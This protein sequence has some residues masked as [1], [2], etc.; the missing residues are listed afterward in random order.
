MGVV[1]QTKQ[2]IQSRAN[3]IQIKV[4]KFRARTSTF[5]LIRTLR[6]CN[7]KSLISKRVEKKKKFL[8]MKLL[9]LFFHKIRY[10]KS[11]I[12]KLDQ[13]LGEHQPNSHNQLSSLCLTR[14]VGHSLGKHSKESLEQPADAPYKEI[15]QLF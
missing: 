10:R 13:L 7:L 12:N 4:G 2:Q 3:S 11:L 1:K 6:S 14:A 15:Y 8:P 9:L 5:H